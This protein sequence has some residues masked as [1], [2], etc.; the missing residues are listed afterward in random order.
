MT[1]KDVEVEALKLNPGDRA[2]LAQKLLNSLEELSEREIEEL[3][4]KEAMRRK[5]EIETGKVTC[6]KADDVIRSL[7]ARL[8]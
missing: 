3:W 4:I 7:R 6:K 5:E 1:L 8:S 2:D